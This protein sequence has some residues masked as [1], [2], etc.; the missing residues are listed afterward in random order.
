MSRINYLFDLLSL[1]VNEPNG[2][3]KNAS[4]RLMHEGFTPFEID[5]ALEWHS[6]PENLRYIETSKNDKFNPS[7]RVFDLNED[8]IFTNESK[9]FI[10]NQLFMKRLDIIE[11]EEVIDRLRLIG[12]EDM[13][14]EE[15]KM[16][17]SIELPTDDE[18]ME[19]KA[20]IVSIH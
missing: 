8:R 17:F 5:A 15:L 4:E 1:Y 14:L 6:G 9:N 20:K 12:V 7:F 10:I 13:D 16:I 18:N 19:I 11:L 3:L 2:N